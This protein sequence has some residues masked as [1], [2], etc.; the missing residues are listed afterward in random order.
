MKELQ[1]TQQETEGFALRV[2]S[3]RAVM[4]QPVSQDIATW[5]KMGKSRK[6]EP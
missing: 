1:D 5:K 4:E 3:R 2:A 6:T